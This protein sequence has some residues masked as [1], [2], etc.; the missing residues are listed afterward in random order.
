MAEWQKVE[1]LRASREPEPAAALARLKAE[2]ALLRRIDHRTLNTATSLSPRGLCMHGSVGPAVP[3]RGWRRGPRR[4]R[5]RVSIYF[6]IFN[7]L[8]RL[9]LVGLY[10]VGLPRR[11]M[12]RRS[13]PRRSMPRRSMAH[14]RWLTACVATLCLNN[15]VVYYQRVLLFVSLV[16]LSHC[17][18]GPLPWRL[19]G[20]GTMDHV[21]PMA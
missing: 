8:V 18:P 5:H 10:L 3:R 4:H 16:P 11:S 7:R 21:W 1:V 19:R 15:L 6:F 20:T 12:P 9:C 13:M 17:W 14:S 2:A